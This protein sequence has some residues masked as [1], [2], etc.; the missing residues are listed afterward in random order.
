MPILG[1]NR[2]HSPEPVCKYSPDLGSSYKL[3]RML[4]ALRDRCGLQGHFTNSLPI[5]TNVSSSTHDHHVPVS[6]GVT[7][8]AGAC[9]DQPDAPVLSGPRPGA[10]GIPRGALASAALSI[11]SPRP[12]FGEYQLCCVS[13]DVLKRAK[14]RCYAVL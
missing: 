9:Y 10:S 3:Q 1:V 4:S 13:L 12:C 11:P 5:T 2:C 7:G 14:G 6:S 8:E